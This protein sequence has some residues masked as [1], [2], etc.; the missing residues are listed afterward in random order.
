MSMGCMEAVL[1]YPTPTTN[2]RAAAESQNKDVKMEALAGLGA[3]GAMPNIT[4]KVGVGNDAQCTCCVGKGAVVNNTRVVF[5]SNVNALE[6][7]E[8]SL[9][10]RLFS[11]CCCGKKKKKGSSEENQKAIE[12]FQL[13]LEQQCGHSFVAEAAPLLAVVDLH[14]RHDHGKPLRAK[15]VAQITLAVR[16]LQESEPAVKR[17]LSEL[18]WMGEEQREKSEDV[19]PFT[20][21]EDFT[22]FV[23]EVLNVAHRSLNVELMARAVLFIRDTE[24]YDV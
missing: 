7:E 20:G 4:L 3:L 22:P 13:F 10:E 19:D 14:T 18:Q 15:H 1:K 24:G 5:K 11:C 12:M 16:T 21:V 23:R 2:P 6:E 8:P 9:L 17:S